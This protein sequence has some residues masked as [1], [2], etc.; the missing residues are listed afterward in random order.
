MRR[1]SGLAP[2]VMAGVRPTSLLP[3]STT[4]RCARWPGETVWPSVATA[5]RS[6][7]RP[8]ATLVNPDLILTSGPPMIAEKGGAIQRDDG[9]SESRIGI[10]ISGGDA[11]KPPG[12]GL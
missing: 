3:A 12:E 1:K 8:A 9:G 11:G 5:P 2:V 6:A 4:A 7:S 10:G